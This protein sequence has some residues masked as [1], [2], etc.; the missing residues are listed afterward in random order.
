MERPKVSH[1]TAVK[2]ILRY[3]KGS[4]ACKILFPKTNTG[5]KYN[6]LG[7]TNSNW[8][9][10]KDDRK[11]T[12][13]YIFMFGGTPI[14]WCSKKELLV[15]LSSCEVEYIVVSL[16][17]CQVMWLMNLLKEL[18]NNDG[19]V[20][21]LLVDNVF[22]INV[23]NNPTTHGRSMHIEMRFYYLISEGR[24]KLRYCRSEEQV[25]DLLTKGVTIEVF[26]RMKMSMGMEDLENLNTLRVL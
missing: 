4:I 23:A 1:L 6:L 5:R 17:V 11:F 25:V 24:L 19:D 9:I 18:G 3:V 14:Y 10:D 20:V 7:F 8:C 16:C 15:A 26:K 22:A 21:T 13:G 2:R 12:V